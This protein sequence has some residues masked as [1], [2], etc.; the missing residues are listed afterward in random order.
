[1]LL[2]MDQKDALKFKEGVSDWIDNQPM[3]MCVD[4]LKLQTVRD[5]SF[6]FIFKAY[7]RT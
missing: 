3:S 5:N 2:K 7:K 4:V 6:P 1:M